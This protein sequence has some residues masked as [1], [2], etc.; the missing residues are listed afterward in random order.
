MLDHQQR[1]HSD[2]SGLDVRFYMM[3]PPDVLV[4]A[5]VGWWRQNRATEGYSGSGLQ[6][7][8]KGV[9]WL[10]AIVERAGATASA[11]TG[12]RSISDI[13]DPM[14]QVI[15]A[16]GARDVVAN[17]ATLAGR[18]SPGRGER[19]GTAEDRRWRAPGAARVGRREESH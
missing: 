18:G 13:V 16:V 7:S 3:C 1:D 17:H 4:A 15:R 12:G 2:W 11:A 8:C 5:T 6:A 10:V 19:Q 14:C 9:R